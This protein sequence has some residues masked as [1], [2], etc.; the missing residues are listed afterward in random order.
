M[1]LQDK[2]AGELFNLIDKW[3][4]ENMNSDAAKTTYGPKTK[5]EW[6][7]R[8]L[9]KANS[10]RKLGNVEQGCALAGELFHLVQISRIACQK[11]AKEVSVLQQ[12]IADVKEETG[13]LKEK[14]T[15]SESNDQR[16]NSTGGS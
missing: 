11:Y 16:G 3:V 12:Q 6:Q 13:T 1:S 2:S 14:L 7:E 10:N 15:R 5:T 9:T 4:V 8:F